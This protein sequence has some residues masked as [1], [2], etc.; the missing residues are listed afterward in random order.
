MDISGSGLAAQRARLDLIANN[1]A[2]AETTRT[3]EGGP[4][5][6][7]HLLLEE[8][9]EQ[10]GVR[11]VEVQQDPRPVRLVHQPGHPDANEQGYVEMP[12]VNVVEEMVDL[13]SATRS[14]E[15]NVTALNAG[16]AMTRKALEIG[17]A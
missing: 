17:R 3:A 5:K 13:V 12:N 14:Y 11:V 7:L 9:H 10:G 8:D 1:L 6:R 15:A 4:Y 2:N 16:K